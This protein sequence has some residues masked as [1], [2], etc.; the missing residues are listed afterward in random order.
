[1]KIRRAL[2][3]LGAAGLFAAS[4]QAHS[5]LITGGDAPNIASAQAIVDIVFAIDTSASM[6]DDIA[7]IGAAAR[8]VVA[9]LNCPQIDCFVRA[10]FMGLSTNSG[11]TFNENVRSYVLALGGTPTTNSSEDNGPAVIDLINH[12]AWGTDAG[13]GQKNYHAIVTI[14]DEGTQDGAPVAQ[15]D[16]D[17]AYQANQL[18]IANNILLFAWATDDPTAGVPNLFS[19]MADGGTGGVSTTYTFADTGGSFLQGLSG[20][21][22]E[23]RLE[24]IICLVAG[25]GDTNNIP[26]PMTLALFSV[27]LAGLGVTRRKRSATRIASS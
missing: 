8:S 16:W 23:R 9:N 17:V 3:A 6:S 27:A 20:V 12:Y 10:R 7:V 15:N 11:T 2:S 26:E 1:M 4:F 24:E 5:A 19:K 14:G 13:P 21:D 22:V 25:G 18:A